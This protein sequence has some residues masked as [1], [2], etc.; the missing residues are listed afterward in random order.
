MSNTELKS[1]ISIPKQEYERLK[2]LD[3]Q[4]DE[5]LAYASNVRDIAAAR[6]EMK[7]KKVF[8]QEKLFKQLGFYM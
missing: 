1:R 4:F 3:A 2:K 7:Q 8:S 5:L 6:K